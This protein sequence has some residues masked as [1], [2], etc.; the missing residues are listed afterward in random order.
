MCFCRYAGRSG[1]TRP[2][3]QPQNVFEAHLFPPF[4][5][6][7]LRE[8]TRDRLQLFLDGKAKKLSKSVIS[9]LRWDLNAVFKMAADDALIHGNP[10]GSLVTPRM[11][12][13]PRGAS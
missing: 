2:T 4:E 5:N 9:H 7:E 3:Q 11:R 10:A 8:R 13:P 1:R 6:S 12:A